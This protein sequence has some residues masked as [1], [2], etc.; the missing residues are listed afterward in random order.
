MTI[1]DRIK[2]LR[3]EHGLTQE[4]LAAKSGLGIAT[5]QRVERGERVSPGTIA[6]IAL[7]FNLSATALTSAS[8]PM[9][10]V[11]SEGSYLPL[12][13]I[14]S[15]KQLIDLMTTCSAI[16]FDYMET[17][18]ATIGDLLGRLYEFCRPREDFQI[19]ANPPDRIRLDIEAAKLLKE[20]KVKGLTLSGETYVRTGHEIDDDG[21]TSSLPLLIAKWDETCLVLRVGTGGLVIDRAD[22]EAHM[23]KWHNTSDPRIVRVKDAADA[24]DNEIP[25]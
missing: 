21:G 17:E 19:P 23:P 18:D 13:E 24:D 5:I 15:G 20:L 1:A 3:K 14:T 8:K 16:D 9:S 25:F 22:V 2:Q 4:D 6:S 12:T 10:V 7:V 11:P